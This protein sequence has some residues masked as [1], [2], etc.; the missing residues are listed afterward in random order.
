MS[1]DT[2]DTGPGFPET[3]DIRPR[4]VTIAEAAVVL[5]VPE[6][7]LRK[8]VTARAVPFT[9]IGRHVRFTSA[10]LDDIIAAGEQRP[11][12]SISNL[13]PSRRARRAS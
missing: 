5:N 2:S 11:L 8:K 1:A 10:H 9:L 3:G 12:E 7:W 13:G 4:L 6:N